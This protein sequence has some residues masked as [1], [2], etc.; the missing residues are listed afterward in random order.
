MVSSI[1]K[2][3]SSHSGSF[4]ILLDITKKCHFIFFCRLRQLTLRRNGHYL[5]KFQNY[6]LG[7]PTSAQVILQKVALL[8]ITETVSKFTTPYHRLLVG[9]A[10]F[11]FC[12]GNH[13]LAA[14]LTDALSLSNWIVY[15]STFYKCSLLM[16]VLFWTF[17]LLIRTTFVYSYSFFKDVYFFSSIQ[18]DYVDWRTNCS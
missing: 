13:G 17:I 18:D 12:F 3:G 6:S 2:W 16:F 4:N 8:N 15:F 11:M 10:P 5:L 1:G 9:M 14:E 7:K